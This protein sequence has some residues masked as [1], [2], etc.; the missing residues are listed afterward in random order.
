MRDLVG[1]DVTEPELDRLARADGLLRRMPPSP[2]V[3]A[4]LT[5]AVLAIPGRDRSPRRRR[6]VVVGVAV[7]AALAAA[8]FGVGLWVGGG[9]SGGELADRIVLNPTSAAPSQAQMVI[10]VLPIDPAGNWAMSAE[11]TGLPMLP[12]GGYYE[13]WMTKAGE[14]AVTC[15]R[16]IV[17][18]VGEAHDVWLNAPYKFKEYD[19]W[20]VVAVSPQGEQSD[21]LLDGPVVVP[22]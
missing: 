8:T 20:V 3:P 4:S 6:R 15:G 1:N 10:N 11:V 18:S 7:A 14:L 22:A 17:D 2:E 12:L 13:V 19:R 5:A 16:F 21:R 9:D